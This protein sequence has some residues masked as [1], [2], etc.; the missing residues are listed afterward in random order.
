[1]CHQCLMK[2][3]KYPGVKDFIIANLYT[4]NIIMVLDILSNANDATACNV[5]SKTPFKCILTHMLF[6]PMSLIIA[7]IG[8]VFSN[9]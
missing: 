9:I 7:F 6:G 1:M 3:L 5:I 4:P 8:V 2:L